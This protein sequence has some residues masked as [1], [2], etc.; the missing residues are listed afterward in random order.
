M[1][2]ELVKRLRYY[3]QKANFMGLKE[4]ESTLLL[5]ETADAIDQ[6]IK[7][8]DTIIRLKS[9]GWYLQ[10]IKNDDGGSSIATMQIPEP[11]REET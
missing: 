2:E 5:N 11:P 6:L 3:I 4:A 10:Q 7:Y 9:E 1:C 8:V